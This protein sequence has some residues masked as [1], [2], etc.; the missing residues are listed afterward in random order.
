MSHF[1]EGVSTHSGGVD[2]DR[3]LTLVMHDRGPYSRYHVVKLLRRGG[4]K[5]QKA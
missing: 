1:L 4:S 3:P 2:G 5:A